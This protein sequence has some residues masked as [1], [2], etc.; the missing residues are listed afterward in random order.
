MDADLLHLFIDAGVYRQ[1]AEQF[2][3]PEQCD[4]V[5]E[6]RLLARLKELMLD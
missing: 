2:L 3:L 6:A 5:D 4:S 1:Y